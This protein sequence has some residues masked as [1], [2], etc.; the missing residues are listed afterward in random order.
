MPD[1]RSLAPAQFKIG[2][3]PLCQRLRIVRV[4]Q[5][6]K[7]N[8]VQQLLPAKASAIIGC[9]IDPL[10]N[11]LVAIGRNTAFKYLYCFAPLVELK[12]FREPLTP[13]VFQRADP[14]CEEQFRQRD[15]TTQPERSFEGPLAKS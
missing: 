11:P 1:R 4:G 13:D 2:V 8:R 15:A 6:G 9:D 3:V 14:F 5:N 7:A 12:S 10:F